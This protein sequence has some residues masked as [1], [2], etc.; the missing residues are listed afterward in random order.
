MKTP[1]H[2]SS[3][4]SPKIEDAGY[5]M[6]PN[7]LIKHQADLGI[8]DP[9]MVTLIALLSF[10]WSEAM[11]FPS[12]SKIGEYTGKSTNSVRDNL[13]SLEAKNLVKRVHR[14]GTSNEYDFRPLVKK[15]ETYKH[16]LESSI[17]AYRKS[18]SQ[19]YRKSDTKEETLKKTEIRKRN[20]SS[21]KLVSVG[22]VLKY[23]KYP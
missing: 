4:W 3:R 1:Y 22:D 15:L 5:T 19:P 21:G 2:F 14:P 23:R 17:P 9:Q 12:A 11:P 7:L 20:G 8:A 6:V 18:S 16:H 10:K 13:R